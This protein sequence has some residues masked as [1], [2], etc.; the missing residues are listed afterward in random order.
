MGP[1]SG[2]AVVGPDPLAGAVDGDRPAVGEDPLWSGVPEGHSD[3][4]HGVRVVP[5]DDLDGGVPLGLPV[6]SPPRRVRHPRE[7]GCR[8]AGDQHRVDGVEDSALTQRAQD[9]PE[10]LRRDQVLAALQ[11]QDATIEHGRVLGEAARGE[12]PLR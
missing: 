2:S 9:E 4:D 8:W 1:R 3:A 10:L 6:R 7:A 12:D 5:L 11:Q